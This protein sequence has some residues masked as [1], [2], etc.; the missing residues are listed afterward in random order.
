MTEEIKKKIAERQNAN[1]QILDKLKNY[2]LTY[3][4]MRFGQALANLNIIEYDRA[5]PTP[6]VI[7]P[8]YDES[9]DI[10]QRV[11]DTIEKKTN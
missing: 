5:K 11:T 9:V 1:L 6:E 3:P 4:D 10:L 7:D 8:F 2:M